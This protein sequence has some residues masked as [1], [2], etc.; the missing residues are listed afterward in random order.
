MLLLTF[1]TWIPT[2]RKCDGIITQLNNLTRMVL[3]EI[4]AFDVAEA[5][6][7]M[8]GFHGYCKRR[9][10]GGTAAESGESFRPHVLLTEAQI[11]LNPN[12]AVAHKDG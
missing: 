7:E 2:T 10:L 9:R 3:G 5:T 4:A 8:S 11:V 1:C 6:Q 12:G